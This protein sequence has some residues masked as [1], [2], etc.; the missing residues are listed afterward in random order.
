MT[1]IAD[2]EFSYLPAQS[3]ELGLIA[4]LPTVHRVALTTAVSALA[5]GQGPARVVFLHGAALNAHTWDDTLLALN[6]RRPDAGAPYLVLDLPGHG[7]SPWRQDARYAPDAIAPAVRDALEQAQ[8]DGLLADHYAIVGQSLGG[9]VALELAADLTLTHLALTHLVLVDVVP[10][11]PGAAATVAEFLS[12]PSSFA[13]REEIVERALAFG[14]GGSRASLERGVIHNTRVHADGRVVWKHHLGQVGAA[15]LRLP[16]A[17]PG[18]ATV[19]STRARLDLVVASSSIVDEASRARLRT[20][21]A[22]AD[23]TEL[24]GGHNLQE[25]APVLLA[26]HLDALLGDSG[27][28]D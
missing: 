8:Q 11:P 9:L 24:P 25:D 23:V 5:W 6:A 13:S 16:D 20:L 21:R 26:D 27:A 19:A 3:G 7:E 22:S 15:G 10:L 12:G 4:P 1:A 28:L 18:W 14:L 2:A 17:E